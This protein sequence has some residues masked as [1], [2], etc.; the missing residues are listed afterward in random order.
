M[1]YVIDACNLI[2]SERRLEETLERH[3]FPTTR[4]LLAGILGRFARAAGLEEIVAV[5]DGSEKAM[6]RPRIQREELGKVVLVYADPREKADQYI[7]DLV[8]NA[9]QPGEITVVSNDKFVVR[10]VQRASGHTL[11]CLEF[12]RHMRAVQQRAADPL[13]GEDPRKFAGPLTSREVDEW[14]KWFENEGKRKK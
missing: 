14:L 9:P 3:G 13:G 10:E 8:R 6:H 2:F 4:N 5:F 1:K 12:Q 7:I 11:S